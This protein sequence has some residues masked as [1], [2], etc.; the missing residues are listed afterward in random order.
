ILPAGCLISAG[1]TL[2]LLVVILPAECLISAGRFISAG[3]FISADRVY[4]PAV[5]MDS[6][7]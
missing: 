1:S 2:F 5:Y 4:V 6:A 3:G 7:I